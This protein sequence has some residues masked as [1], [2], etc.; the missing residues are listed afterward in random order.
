[1]KNRTIDDLLEDMVIV[2]QTTMMDMNM[3]GQQKVAMIADHKAEAHA[4]LISLFDEVVGG[5]REYGPNDLMR[6]EAMVLVAMI[7]LDLMK[8]G[9]LTDDEPAPTETLGDMG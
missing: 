9:L 3:N 8:R 2:G 5:D 7:A 4:E 1:M 6:G